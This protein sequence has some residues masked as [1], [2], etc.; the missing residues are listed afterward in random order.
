MTDSGA[1][2]QSVY[3]DVGITNRETLEFQRSIGSEILVPLDIATSP[4]ADRPTAESD[5]SVTM[6]RIRES[7]EIVGLDS[8]AAPVQ[9]GK[10]PDLR[11]QAGR[12]VSGMGFSLLPHR[13][14]GAFHGGVPV[15]GTGREWSS[16]RSAAYRRRPA[17]TSSGP[18][19]RRCS[20]LRSPWAAMS[21]TLRPMPS[22][23]GTAGT[24]PPR[25]LSISTRSSESG[26]PVRCVPG[27]LGTGP[28]GGPRPGSAPRTAQPGHH[29]HRDG[30]DP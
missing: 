4:Q 15:P 27:P 11:E 20:P 5:L 23:R 21:S 14:C 19:T 26:L 16:R 8:L 10:Y 9:G 12:A 13:R 29:P 6:D 7:V 17:S 28:Q 30:P 2:Q 25:D 18:G 22:L 3:G 24:S 1:F